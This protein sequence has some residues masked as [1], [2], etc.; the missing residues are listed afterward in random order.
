M[1]VTDDDDAI[2]CG[3]AAVAPAEDG[4]TFAGG[5]E[6]PGE[7]CDNG[8]LSAA[9]DD[10]VADADDRLCEL[11]RPIRIPAIPRAAKACRAPV[12]A[13]EQTQ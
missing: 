10:Q 6:E 7:C 1:D 3:K 5:K 2:G 8:S 9:A 13:A 11:P 12:D 4:G